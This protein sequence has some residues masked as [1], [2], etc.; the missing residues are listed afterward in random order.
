MIVRKANH[1]HKYVRKVIGKNK[2]YRV[3]ACALPDCN[4]YIA[5]ELV[6]GKNSI[7]W[8]CGDVCVMR[9]DKNGN[10]LRK[11]HCKDCTRLPYNKELESNL[12]RNK[13]EKP[14]VNV[15]LL[16]DMLLAKTNTGS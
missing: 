12:K 8:R 6:E 16:A 14:T 1:V 10:F 11:P 4:H 9:K 5:E 2:A 7:C 15:S 3:F 13:K